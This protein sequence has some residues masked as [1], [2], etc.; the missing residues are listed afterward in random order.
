MALKIVGYT[1]EAEKKRKLSLA[2][3]VACELEFASQKRSSKGT[4]SYSVS[5]KTA[6]KLGIEK[7]GVYKKK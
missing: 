1:P 5:Q 2:E 3:R 7:K 6:E 4:V